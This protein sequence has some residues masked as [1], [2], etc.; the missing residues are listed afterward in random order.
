MSKTTKFHISFFL[1]IFLLAFPVQSFA[2]IKILM[3]G[4]SLTEGYG[5][6]RTEAYPVLTEE[7]LKEKGFEVKVFNAGISGSTTASALSRLKWH[8]RSRPE[9]LFLALGANDGLRGLDTSY[10]KQNLE[11]TIRFAQEKNMFVVLAGMQMPPNYGGAYTAE[12]KRVFSD[13]AQKLEISFL[14]F[15]LQGVGGNPKFNQADGI[16]PNA[17]GHQII[18][19]MVAKHLAEVLSEENYKKLSSKK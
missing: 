15:L 11:K 6:N 10:M 7:L 13:V 18:A 4:D 5:V 8:S 17:E 9:I 2:E 12:F 14:P 1:F 16:H 19:K 3:L